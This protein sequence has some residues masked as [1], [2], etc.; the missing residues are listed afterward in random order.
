MKRIKLLALAAAMVLNAPAFAQDG[1]AVVSKRAT[2]F[3]SEG[4]KIG[5][6]EQVVKGDDGAPS[7]VKI[8]YRGK[9]LTIPASSLTADAGGFKTSLSN[10]E[11][12]K[13]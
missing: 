1:A 6:V 3:S 9:F 7:A 11:I 13:M 2:I 4:T 8:I 5:R 12:K 10:D